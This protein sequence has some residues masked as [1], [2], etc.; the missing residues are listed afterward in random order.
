MLRRLLLGTATAAR[1]IGPAAAQDG[2]LDFSGFAELE[3]R[4]YPNDAAHDRQ[5]NRLAEPTIAVQP[6]LRYDLGDHRFTLVP[7]MR[8]APFD[9]EGRTHFDLRE[10]NWYYAAYD[11]DI[12][13]GLGKVFWGKTESRHLVDIVNQ[14]DLVEDLDGEDKLGQPMVNFNYLSDGFGA[15]GLFVMPGF[16]ERTFP[17]DTA[18]GRGAIN[19]DTDDPIFEAGLGRAHP[20][21]AFRWSYTLGDYDLGISHFYG[22]S[23]EPRFELAAGQD[24]GS[25]PRLRPVYD[26]IHQ[27]G[28]DLQATKGAWLLKFEGITRSGHTDRFYAAVGGVEYTL[29]QLFESDADLGLLAEYLYDGREADEG[30]PGTPF[31][32]DVFG[33]VR[34]ALNDVEDTGLL[35]GAVIDLENQGILALIEADRRIGDSWSVELESRLFLNVPSENDP[36]SGVREDGYVGLRLARYF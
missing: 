8:Y 12:T 17:G 1:L 28:I 15:F 9:T 13:V 6:E 21:I 24:G 26:L 23:R 35:A 7:F 34:L 31:N 4:A 11:W 25:S 18:R 5:T 22:T 3:V 10:A 29:F 30:D 32:N 36:L 19:V 16:R 2:E 33:G 14:S 27:T 20:D